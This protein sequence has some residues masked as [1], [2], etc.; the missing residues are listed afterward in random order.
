MLFV[1]TGLAHP[2]VCLCAFVVVFVSVRRSLG[3]SVCLSVRPS[4]HPSVSLLSCALVCTH[5]LVSAVVPVALL[6]AADV[7]S[8]PNVHV[9][10][11]VLA[12]CAS[13][14]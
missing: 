2:S 12:F 1:F 6:S 3:L 8:I 13:I 4:A 10:G 5:M 11:A 7:V 14:G 9:P